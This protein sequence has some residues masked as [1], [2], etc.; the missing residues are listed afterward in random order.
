MNRQPDF[1]RRQLAA[2]HVMRTQLALDDDTYRAMLRQLT[3]ADSAA[4]LNPQQR[5]QVLDHLTRLKLA[6]VRASDRAAYPERPA[7]TDSNPQLQKIEALL[8][9]AKQPW[10]YAVGICKRVCKKDRL[11]WCTSAEL[12]KVIAALTYH[13]RRNGRR[14]G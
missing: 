7:T 12:G 4:E 8:T 13:A 1:R 5:G 3:G 10:S 6:L 11:E 14:T 2:I 9:E